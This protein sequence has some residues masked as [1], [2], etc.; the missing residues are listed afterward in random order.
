MSAEPGPR[1]AAKVLVEPAL[2][3]INL[4]LEVLARAPDGY[5]LIESLVTFADLGERVTATVGGAAPLDVSGPQAGAL[6]G[7]ANL[8][9]AADRALREEFPAT[10]A[11]SYRLAKHIPVAAG[12]GGGSADAA[13]VLRLLARLGGHGTTAAALAR[14]GLGIGADVPVCIASRPARVTGIGE[15]VEL[16]ANMPGLALVL[17]NPGIRLETRAVFEALDLAPGQHRRGRAGARVADERAAL[18]EAVISGRNDLE[19]PAR[20]LVP[21]IGEVVGAIA[22][23]AGCLAARM[24]GSGA[25]AFGIFEDPGAARRAASDLGRDR[26]GWWVRAVTSVGFSASG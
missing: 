23:T 11:V 14:I 16:L 20:R 21:Q 8:V 3:K 19:P 1:S 13:A 26:A 25:T 2:A 15:G 22:R 24:S 7:E 18:A 4:T 10:P 12:L 6:A 9:E 5:H 17:V